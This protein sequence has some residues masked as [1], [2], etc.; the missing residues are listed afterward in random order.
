VREH[1]GEQAIEGWSL[2]DM[3]THVHE[4][5]PGL[6]RVDADEATYPL[7]VILR[8]EIEQDLITGKLA[9][10]D[11]P[12]IWDAKMQDYLGL[13]TI[14]NPAD[15]PMQ[16]VHWPG[17]AFGYF[18]SYTLGALMAAQQWAAIEKQHP[19]V[20]DWRQK[21][22]WSKA[23][24]HSTPELMQLATGEPLTPKHFIH[25]LEARYG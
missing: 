19:D 21:N 16:D 23:S 14:G 10:K 2:D 5:K 7:H 18:P 17:G 22:I 12:E 3:L 15:G 6:I 8:F 4:I 9:P 25:H 11:V 13:S 20:T 1:L 24:I